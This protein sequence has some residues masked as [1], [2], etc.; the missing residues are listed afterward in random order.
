MTFYYLTFVNKSTLFQQSQ[1]MFAQDFY[2]NSFSKNVELPESISHLVLRSFDPRTAFEEDFYTLM[3]Q[4]PFTNVYG[5]TKEEIEEKN[6][7]P[8]LLP[9]PIVIQKPITEEM[10]EASRKRKE[11][12]EQKNRE[13]LEA[14][15]KIECGCDPSPCCACMACE[16]CC[17][18]YE[19]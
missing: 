10:L 8:Q 6:I 5:M 19:E 17:H 7:V 9:H 1:K 14:F 11:E 13:F 18:L 15:E 3:T 12:G 4:S 2:A 16:R